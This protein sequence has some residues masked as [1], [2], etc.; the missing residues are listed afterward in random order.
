MRLEI[1]TR[2]DCPAT[3]YLLEVQRPRRIGV[4]AGRWRAQRDRYGCDRHA[5]PKDHLREQRWTRA[6][7]PRIATVLVVEFEDALH[8]PAA[9]RWRE[10]FTDIARKAA[11]DCL[12]NR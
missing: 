4:E 6:L 2:K 1:H 12:R 3:L 5:T 7:P 10:L 11:D 8:D 9:V